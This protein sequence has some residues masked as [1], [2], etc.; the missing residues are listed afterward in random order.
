MILKNISKDLVY[1]NLNL[2]VFNTNADVQVIDVINLQNNSAKT[3]DD[4]RK[5][6]SQWNEEEIDGKRYTIFVNRSRSNK[7]NVDAVTAYKAQK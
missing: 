1:E 2:K 7:E 3:T 4:V 5:T 6:F